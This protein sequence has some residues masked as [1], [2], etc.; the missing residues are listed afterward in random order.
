MYLIGKIKVASVIPKKL[1]RLREFAYN[2]WWSWNPE[3]TDLFDEMDCELWAEVDMNPVRFVREVS[4][5]KLEE[6]ISDPLYMK[7]YHEIEGKFDSYMGDSNT[8]FNKTY[9]ECSRKI[10]YFSAEYGLNEVLPVYSGGLG[11]L[12]GDHLKSASDLGLPLTAVGLLYK[13]GYFNQHI[14]SE[15]W[16]E[17]IYPELNMSQLPVQEVYDKNGLPVKISVELPGRSV[18]AKVWKVSVG[19]V[20]LYLMDTDIEENAVGDRSLTGILYGG[21]QETRIQQEI[22][23]GIGGY[24]AL[25]ALGIFPGV[26]HMNEGHSAFLGLELI[27]AFMN[28]QKLTFREAKEAVAS[29]LVFT[30]HT[31]VPAGNDVFPFTMIDKYYHNYWGSLGI[32]RH[33]FMD[34]GSKP[35]DHHNFNMT[36]LA[37]KLAGRRNAVSGLHGSV[38]RNIFQNVWNN[39]PENEV[40]IKHITNGI[41]TFT[42]ISRKL[43]NTLDK[44]LGIPWKQN[45]HLTDN[46]VNV[47]NIPNDELWK[48][49]IENKIDMVQFIRTKLKE[50]RIKNIESF[51]SIRE[52]ENILNPDSLIIGFAR[53]FA[54]YKRANLIFRNIERIKRIINNPKMP[55]QIVFAGKAHPADIPA[56]DIIKNIYE[57]SRQEAFGGKVI[58]L[59]NYNMRTAGKLIKGVDVWLNNPRRPLEASGTSGQKAALNGVL[60]FSVLDGWWCEAYNGSNGWIIGSD[61]FY[62]DE[63]HQDNADSEYL[64]NVLEQLIIPLYYERDE[65]GTPCKWVEKMKE[66]IG[67]I[68]SQYSTHRMVIDYCNKMYIPSIERIGYIL[69][70]ENYNVKKLAEWKQYMETN[71]SDVKIEAEKSMDTL[72]EK[73]SLSG[74]VINLTCNV[75]LGKIPPSFVK[76]E[77]YFGSIKDGKI[78]GDQQTVDMV[79]M[80]ESG[81]DIYRYSANL[82]VMESGEYGYTFRV[83][84]YSPGLI[85]KF[86][87]GLV[88]WIV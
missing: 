77:V 17:T 54:T 28:E 42:W 78:S 6:K 26:Y 32:G 82:K 30:T 15:G 19:R 81:K 9:P 22:L 59:E 24:R 20:D 10:A 5:K 84:P 68:S 35:G 83:V 87:T 66:S 4:Q 25:K 55:V 72:K 33:E 7:K 85:D 16:Q 40:P 62:N 71:W 13:H 61:S 88:R 37:L 18:F 57:I 65:K 23:L 49:H 12:S 75:Y 21:D 41:H 56:H 50:Q 47:K 11:V 2:L 51:E 14:N 3:A 53:R 74:N 38:S 43:S 29:C 67:T 70:E 48:I 63:Y 79:M 86:E 80:E 69:N 45:V 39:V 31:S 44:H 64:Y 34:L 36:I 60:N 46:W 27:K 52:A 76:V 73:E 8:W 58:I 1:A